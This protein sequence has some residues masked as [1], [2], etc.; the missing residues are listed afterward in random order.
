MATQ[1]KDQQSAI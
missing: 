1:E